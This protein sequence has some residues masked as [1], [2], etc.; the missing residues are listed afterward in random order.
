MIRGTGKTCI[1]FHNSCLSQHRLE[2]K[3][4]SSREYIQDY[5][6]KV[7]QKFNVIWILKTIKKIRVR[8]RPPFL[9]LRPG[10]GIN[11]SRH[12]PIMLYNRYNKYLNLLLENLQNKIIQGTGKTCIFFHNHLKTFRFQVPKNPLGFFRTYFSQ[13]ELEGKHPSSI[14][15]NNHYLN[16]LEK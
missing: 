9:Y 5:Y 8:A 15:M 1:F 10:L 12:R 7:S 6:L 16:I 14:C 3:H 13:Y 4:P 2:G 11:R